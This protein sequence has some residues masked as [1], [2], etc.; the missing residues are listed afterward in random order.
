[1]QDDDSTTRLS[2]IDGPS[3]A[4]VALHSHLPEPAAEMFDVRLANTFDAKLLNQANDMVQLCPDV[5]WKGVKF[6]QNCRIE[7]LDAPTQ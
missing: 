5:G 7:D 2:H 4:A 1:M 3:Q 6:R